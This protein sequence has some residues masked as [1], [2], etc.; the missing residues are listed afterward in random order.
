MDKKQEV[1]LVKEQNPIDW[2]KFNQ[3]KS[4]AKARYEANPDRYKTSFKQLE[5]VK[6]Y[7]MRNKDK[8]RT[9]RK[10]NVAK[11]FVKQT[12][13]IARLAQIRRIVNDRLS[14]LYPKGKK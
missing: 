12:T 4:R 10:W 7:R 9:N 13:N 8:R 14:N 6:L 1:G 5:S 11:S 3:W 2:Q